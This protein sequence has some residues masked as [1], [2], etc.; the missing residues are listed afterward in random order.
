MNLS[1]SGMLVAPAPSLSTGIETRFQLHLETDD[2][3]IGVRG[4][5]IAVASDGVHVRF[6]GDLGVVQGRVRQLAELSIVPELETSLGD[7]VRDIDKLLQLAAWYHELGRTENAVDLY[8]TVLELGGHDVAFLTR[9]T[10]PLIAQARRLG[11]AAQHV[12]PALV[13]TI[14]Q[15]LRADPTSPLA[16]FLEQ[17]K[18]LGRIVPVPA[19]APAVT[20][21]PP[22]AAHEIERLRRSITDNRNQLYA[23]FLQLLE[24]RNRLRALEDDTRSQAPTPATAHN[25]QPARPGAPETLEP[26]LLAIHE[27]LAAMQSHEAS[28]AAPTPV[29]SPPTAAQIPAPTPV[30]TTPAVTT[31]TAPTR[32]AAWPV[33]VAAM[34]LA[35]LAG[36]WWL[37]QHPALFHMFTTRRT[38]A[39]A[40]FAPAVV[41]PVATPSVAPQPEPATTD[42]TT[43][44]S[45]EDEPLPG[46]LRRGGAA[47]TPRAGRWRSQPDADDEA[48]GGVDTPMAPPPA[49]APV[50]AD[51]AL[52]AHYEAGIA[53]LRERKVLLAIEELQRCVDLDPRFADAYRGLGLAYLMLEQQPQ[54]VA[55]FERFVA[56][57][58]PGPLVDRAIAVIAA[59]RAS[60]S[61]KPADAN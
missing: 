2:E 51:V 37:Y 36:A 46:E 50:T 45:A 43:A 10:P 23:G 41:P 26:V 55:A 52:R 22:S 57:A 31:R 59:S 13:S 47:R 54:A 49:A 3:A 8:R 38:A 33:P 42:A 24:E 61:E 16:S 48:P 21:P 30:L 28:S 17:A 6:V 7:A 27:Q 5:V 35:L 44:A 12:A 11:P 4:G 56:L 32:R 14:E 18:L 34:V 20:P 58:P 9:I 53:Y 29:R 1:Q 60:S 19:V 15:V 25:T 40:A 39:P